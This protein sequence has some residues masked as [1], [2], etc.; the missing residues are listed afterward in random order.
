MKRKYYILPSDYCKAALAEYEK[1]KAAALAAK[2]ALL[3]EFGCVAIMRSGSKGIGLAYSSETDMS[4]FCIPRL[5]D[6]YYVSKPKVNTIRGK[7]AQAKI[8]ECC[9]LLEVW[10]WALENALGVYGIVRDYYGFHHL[11][12]QPLPDGRVVLN[13]PD[14]T[15][16]PR[17]QSSSRNFDGPVIPGCAVEV[18]LDEA[19]KAGMRDEK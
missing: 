2:D 13:A 6:G 18:S 14:G 11:V 17:T 8:D 5:M 10:Q 3:Q 15:N 4:G 9:R 1:A 16:S 12:A 7:A 19:V